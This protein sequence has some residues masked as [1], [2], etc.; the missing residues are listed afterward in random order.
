MVCFSASELFRS[1]VFWAPYWSTLLYWR[2]ISQ[3][4]SGSIF[5]WNPQHRRVAAIPH[6]RVRRARPRRRRQNHA[7]H[8]STWKLPYR[9]FSDIRKQLQ[10]PT[11]LN[12]SKLFPTETCLSVDCFEPAAS[13]SFSLAFRPLLETLSP[14]CLALYPPRQW[15]RAGR[16]ASAQQH[17]RDFAN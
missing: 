2:Y 13:I 12:A 10:I 17:Y 9:P 8:V 6:F 11:K 1:I 7:N 15:W 5:L 14:S 16:S 4:R 3:R